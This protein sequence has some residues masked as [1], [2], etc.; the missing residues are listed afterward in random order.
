VIANLFLPDDYS[1]ADRFGQVA[2]TQIS[3]M[4]LRFTT[5]LDAELVA[6]SDVVDDAISSYTIGGWLRENGTRIPVVLSG[7]AY[8]SAD[9][10]AVSDTV[11]ASAEAIG[12]YTAQATGPGTVTAESIAVGMRAGYVSLVWCVDPDAQPE[13]VRGMTAAWCDRYGLPSETVQVGAPTITTAAQPLATPSGT[14]TDT[15]IVSGQ[16]PAAGLDIT[17]EGFL[18]PED[19]ELPVCEAGNVTYTS[20]S[21][22]RVN[23]P[24]EYVSEEFPVTME[25]LGTVYWVETARLPDGTLVHEGECGLPNE[26]TLVQL[27][28]VTTVATPDVWLGDPASDTALLTGMV[29]EGATV[30]FNAYRQPTG[31]PTGA[32][33]MLDEDGVVLAP[34]CDAATRVFDGTSSPVVAPAGNFPDGTFVDG[35]ETVFTEAG[36][37]YWVETLRDRDGE[38]LHQGECGAPNETTLASVPELPVTGVP[39]GLT[40]LGVGASAAALLGLALLTGTAA[41][42]RRRKEVTAI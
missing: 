3:P 22:I 23:E 39:A 18:Q 13:A 15:A 8:W 17:F 27:V 12:T 28:E 19:A 1:Y 41:W 29:P 35:P 16:V 4:Q 14:V 11:P 31:T 32:G 6:I 20:T 25:H 21:P 40:E 5:E 42:N 38:I 10:P 33:G 2:E 30:T 37:H 7:T 24:G 36:T 9:E 26:T 34:V